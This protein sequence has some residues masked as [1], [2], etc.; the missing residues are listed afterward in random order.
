MIHV[1]VVEDDPLAAELLSDYISTE[2]MK[3]VQHY[4]SAEQAVAD[5]PRLPL[6]D[7]ILMDIGLPGMDG[8]QATELLKQK[9]EDLEILMLTTFED[10]ETIIRAIK[11][12][13]SGYMLKASRSG[14]ICAAIREVKRGGSMLSGSVARKLVS[15]FQQ[16]KATIELE[17]LTEREKAILKELISGK[18]YKAIAADLD[19]SV[20]TVNN[21]IRHIY[22]K[23]HVNSRAE[24]VAL[25][26][27]ASTH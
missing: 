14:E 1:A 2:D 21:H 11:A 20:H 13:A 19:I 9:F 24:A 4:P 7:V 8:I 18:S 3:V 27:Q 23:L 17:E 22:K 26:T 6:P 12:G 25:A 16:E 5:I 10:T 15:E